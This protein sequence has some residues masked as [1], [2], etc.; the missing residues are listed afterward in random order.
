MMNGMPGGESF[1]RYIPVRFGDCDPAGIVFYPRYFE[2]FNN[3]VEDWCAQELGVGFRDMHLAQH[4]GVPTVH[5]ETDFVAPSELGEV[6]QARLQVRRIGGSSLHVAI[7]LCGPDDGERV[8]AKLVLAAMDLRERRAV[9]LPPEFARKASRFLVAA[10]D[11]NQEQK[12][13]A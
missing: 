5:L 2:M 4:W 3:L 8:R 10:A 1:R 6:L 13:T 11:D 12:G 9:P 7:Q